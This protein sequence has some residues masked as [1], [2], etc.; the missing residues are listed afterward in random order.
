MK[1][2]VIIT[3]IAIYIISIFLVASLGINNSL[4]YEFVYVTG[5]DGTNTEG[6]E[7]TPNATDGASGK[8]TIKNYTEGM[9]IQLDFRPNPSNATES[10][11]KYNIEQSSMGKCTILE[12]ADGT[13]VL[14]ILD[15]S[16]IFINIASRDTK[17]YNIRV[18]IVVEIDNPDW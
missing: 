15:S 18:K 3:I 7:E 1:K 5:I 12:K 9:Q 16:A 2:T 11:L 17:G 13:A 6:Y 8:I 10:K 4:D 14:T